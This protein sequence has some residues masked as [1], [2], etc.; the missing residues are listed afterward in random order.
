M[1]EERRRQTDA[2]IL[3]ERY[4]HLG[5]VHYPKERGPMGVIDQ[6]IDPP[7]ILAARC[8]FCR[9]GKKL[10]VCRITAKSS[11]FGETWIYCAKCGSAGP[12]ADTEDAALAKWNERA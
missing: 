9:E 1:S 8:P 5:A 10:R 12:H 11:V 6:H 3:I 2:E 7:A 4:R